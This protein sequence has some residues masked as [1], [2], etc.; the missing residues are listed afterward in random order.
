MATAR[1]KAARLAAAP[2]AAGSTGPFR[3][4]VGELLL[5]CWA[6]HGHGMGGDATVLGHGLGG[7]AGRTERSRATGVLCR[8][9]A[10]L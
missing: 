6:C 9:C 7:L 4:G 8:S 10:G 1:A 3:D 5:G 2:V